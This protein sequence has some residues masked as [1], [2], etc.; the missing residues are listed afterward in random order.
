VNA[1]RL[2]RFTH[3]DSTAKDWAYRDLGDGTAEIRWGPASQLR[4]SQLK[5]LRE[6]RARAQEKL[7]KGYQDVGTVWLDSQGNRAVGPKPPPKPSQPVDL[8]QLLGEG[9]GFY[10]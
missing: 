6:A 9:N 8:S 5:P 1:F 4:Q 7:R 10:F 2:Y 3:P